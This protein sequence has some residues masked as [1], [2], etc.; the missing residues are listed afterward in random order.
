M[1]R[2]VNTILTISKLIQ[3]KF[4]WR[5]IFSKKDVAGAGTEPESTWWQS[6]TLIT[7]SKKWALIQSSKEFCG[8]QRS[9]LQKRKQFFAS[10]MGNGLCKAH[11]WALLPTKIFASRKSHY[12]FRLACM[13]SKLVIW[14][15]IFGGCSWFVC[16]GSTSLWFIFIEM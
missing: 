2:H 14:L 15:E 7:L 11:L 5:I 3:V 16:Q 12:N 8:K 9:R 1:T 13:P 6:S 10:T 4:N